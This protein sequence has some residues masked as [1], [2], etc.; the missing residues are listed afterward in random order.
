MQHHTLL[1]LLLGSLL[2]APGLLSADVDLLRQWAVVDFPLAIT[3]HVEAGA[4]QE[5]TQAVLRFR[6]EERSCAQVES[7]GYGEVASG[8]QTSAQ[9]T[10][11]M[12]RTGGLPPGAVIHFSWKI[13]DASGAVTES[14]PTTV[15]IVDQ[16][17]QWRSLAGD[18]FT[19][20]WYRGDERFASALAESVQEA[21]AR[22]EASTGVRPD[23]PVELYIYGS[24]REV[25]DA[26][27]FP[28]EWTGGVAF[29]SFN[30][31][32]L[33]IEPES[34]AWGRRAL[35]HELTHVIIG[36]VTHNCYRDLPTW[37]N[38]GLATYNE[39]EFSP[40]Y[41]SALERAVEDDRLFSVRG[42]SGAFPTDG[43]DALLA[44]G[45]SWSL[46]D[47]LV[48]SYGPQKLDELFAAFRSGNATDVALRQVYGLDQ[49]GLDQEWRRSLGVAVGPSVA[50][51]ET[52][53]P[54]ASA[55][56]TFEPFTLA[57][58]P[59]PGG[60][61]TLTAT[62]EPVDSNTPG[63]WGCSGG[64]PLA[65]SPGE[66]EIATLLLPAGPLAFGL[67]AINFRRR[68]R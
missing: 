23:K 12:R 30:T 32:A 50:S 47:Y 56:P 19:L 15:E 67:L 7:I 60:L 3:F 5:I 10:W 58:P 20:H 59:P 55:V 41:A 6:L 11:D 35:A 24:A 39:G 8:P 36:Q 27:V 65:S 34:L 16:Q 44:Y 22:L 31:V 51:G 62:P 29:T 46:L 25:Q 38:E 9:W 17:H 1:P 52:P 68:K 26:L 49:A 63:S 14:A 42:L 21:L 54:A 64:L 4:S 28:Q 2:A 53:T 45:E 66:Q 61:A 43:N 57:S 13:T 48:R 18:G 37:L 33:G 40:D